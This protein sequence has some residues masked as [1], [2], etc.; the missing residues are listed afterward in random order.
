MRITEIDWENTGAS[1]VPEF[2]KVQDYSD[3]LLNQLQEVKLDSIVFEITL[4]KLSFEKSPKLKRMVIRH[5]IDFLRPSIEK[6]NVILKEEYFTFN[7]AMWLSE[8]GNVFAGSC[9]AVLA[10]YEITIHIEKTLPKL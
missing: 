4:I 3:V 9:K 8:I 2:L 7:F 10:K 6:V 1:P 5:R